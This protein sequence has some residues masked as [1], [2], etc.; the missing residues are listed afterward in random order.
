M[1]DT[2]IKELVESGLTIALICVGIMFFK[3][4]TGSGYAHLGD[5]VIFISVL[6]LGKRRGALSA[7]IGGFLADLLGGFANWAI[8]TFIIKYI[9]GY[10]MGSIIKNQHNA[11]RYSWVFGA[12]IG[13]IWQ[14]FGYT[15]ARV[16]MFNVNTALAAI[17]GITIQSATGA[18]IAIV[19]M[20][21]VSKTS[22]A[23]KMFKEA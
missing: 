11:S 1:R 20:F 13:S 8:P 19:I 23:S 10:I 3:I 12:V 14:I 16:F 15:L 22:L 6:M 2:K 4:P 21:A 9:M 18:I 7:G 17:P 5:S